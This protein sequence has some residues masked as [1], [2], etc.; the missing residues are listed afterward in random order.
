MIPGVGVEKESDVFGKFAA[1]FFAILLSSGCSSLSPVEMAPEQVQERISEGDIIRVGD[2]VRLA[3][4]DGEIHEFEVTAVTPEQIV[5]ENIDI[6]ID[7]IVAVETRE[8]SAGKTTA[9]AGGAVLMWAIIV[10]VALG[11]TLAL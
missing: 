10:A 7:D 3:T 5:G 4:R 11:G 6:A 2:T 1:L 9:L 8:F